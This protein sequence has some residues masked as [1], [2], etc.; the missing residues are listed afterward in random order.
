MGSCAPP[1]IFT[2]PVSGRKEATA[3]SERP[4][5]VSGT[6]VELFPGFPPVI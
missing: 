1:Y 6:E 3:Q 2:I 4:F 5:M